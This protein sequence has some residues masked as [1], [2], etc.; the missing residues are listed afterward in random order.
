MPLDRYD[1]V[2]MLQSL[3]DFDLV[4]IHRIRDLKQPVVTS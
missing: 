4:E 3:D 1:F 2:F